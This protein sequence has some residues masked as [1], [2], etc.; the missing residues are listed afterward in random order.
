MELVQVDWIDSCADI[1]WQLL[2]DVDTD[3]TRVTT[4]GFL[5][6]ETNECVVIAQSVGVEPKQVCNTI[7]IP[8]GCIKNIKTIE[9]N[10]N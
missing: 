2:C 1:N 6:K 9:E 4:V 8:K 5:V 3:L 7:A 10:A